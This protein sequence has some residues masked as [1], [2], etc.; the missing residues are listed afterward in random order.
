[1]IKLNKIFPLIASILIASG[2]SSIN[3]SSDY[4]S[5]SFTETGKDIKQ[6]VTEPFKETYS[7]TQIIEKSLYDGLNLANGVLQMYRTNESYSLKLK[8]IEVSFDDGEL[9]PMTTIFKGTVMINSLDGYIKTPITFT[10]KNLL[11]SKY[12]SISG[13]QFRIHNVNLDKVHAPMKTSY[14]KALEISLQ[15]LV[16]LHLNNLELINLDEISGP[17]KKIIN[18]KNFRNK[19][20]NPK[21]EYVN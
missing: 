3:K 17:N 18:S 20:Y 5:D 12:E 4:I 7:D 1:M 19:K 9:G 13:H 14:E 16:S 11:G 6:M 21:I 8:K 10:T 15:N 2:C